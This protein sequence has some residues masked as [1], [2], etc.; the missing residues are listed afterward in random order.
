MTNILELVCFFY[1]MSNLMFEK[2]VLHDNSPQAIAGM[3][4]GFINFLLPSNA[5][6]E[7]FFKV[8]ESYEI[9]LPYE[10]ALSR[11]F[12]VIVLLNRIL[13]ERTLLQKN[14]LFWITFAM[15]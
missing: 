1:P 3:I 4:I 5:I 2:Y 10:E 6:N 7:F 12:T 15:L 11:I 13:T 8:R 9:D 14:K